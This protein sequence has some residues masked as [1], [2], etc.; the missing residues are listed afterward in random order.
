MRHTD[1]PPN[2]ILPTEATIKHLAMREKLGELTDQEWDFVWDLLAK[3]GGAQVAEFDEDK[4][5][6]DAGLYAMVEAEAFMERHPD[7]D[8]DHVAKKFTQEYHMVQHQLYHLLNHF[9]LNDISGFNHPQKA[10]RI[11]KLFRQMEV[12]WIITMIIDITTDGAFTEAIQAAV[13][14]VNSMT[15]SDLK[16]MQMFIDPNAA[17]SEDDAKFLA[18]ELQLSGMNLPEIL[19]IARHLDTL[20]ELQKDKSKLR[21]DPNGEDT[22][23]RDIRD[24]SEL[25][26]VSQKDLALPPM[27]RYQRAVEGTLNVRDPHTRQSKKQLL[28]L[29]IDGTGSMMQYKALAASRAAGVALNRLQAVLDGDA[30]VYI[31]FFDWRLREVEYHAHDATSARELM[32]IVSD[33]V[34]YQGW[35]TV[36]D[37][38]LKNASDRIL[39]LMQSGKL[40][41]PELV[42]VTD[43]SADIPDVSVLQ[44]IKMHTVQV[45]KEEVAKLSDL[46]RESGGISVY[47]GVTAGM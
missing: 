9:D 1:T 47:A 41:E 20:S 6:F 10:V 18:L 44:G 24:L 31:R 30:E 7:I 2:L 28:Y 29:V 34:N 12:I 27:L 5:M 16:T 32:T 35:Q 33:P 23:L 22:K 42:F 39:E 26:K 43:G 17:Q 19:R 8:R 37:V 46:A 3:T 36:F 13:D 38:T 11:V 21:S 45:G 25:G 4:A 15:E 40:K 14:E